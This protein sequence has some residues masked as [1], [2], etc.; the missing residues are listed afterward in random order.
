MPS[1]PLWIKTAWVEE[2]DGPYMVA[3][4]DEWTFEAWGEEPEFYT[5]EVKKHTGVRE[6]YVDVPADAV[7]AMFA[8]SRVEGVPRRG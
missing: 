3:S 1:E 8:A 6:M 4:Y 7:R 5:T 2:G